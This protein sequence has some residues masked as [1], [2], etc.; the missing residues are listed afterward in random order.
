LAELCRP[1]PLDPKRHD[2][3][4]FDSGSTDLDEWLRRYSTQNRRRNT[5][6]TWV[7]ADVDRAVV[8]YVSLAMT[9]IDR[10]GAPSSVAKHAPDPVPALLIGRLAVDR[11]HAGLGVGTALVAHVLATAVDLNERAA[12]RAVVVAAL[13]DPARSWWHRLGFHPFDPADDNN[14]GLYLLTGE[15]EATL[16]SLG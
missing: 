4:S 5:A 10:G 12:C 9:S 6:A 13:D 16:R 3:S 15:I 1:E 11:S 7:I 14:L 2:R 8:A